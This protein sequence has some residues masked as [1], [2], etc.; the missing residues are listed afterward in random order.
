[1]ETTQKMRIISSGERGS[2][3]PEINIIT[4]L[5]IHLREM[6]EVMRSEDRREVVSFGISPEKALW[7]SYKASVVRR[8]GYIDGKIAAIWGVAGAFMGEIGQPWLLT[9][10]EV[11]KISPLKFARLYQKEVKEMLTIFPKLMNIVDASYESAV[12][13]LDIVGFKLGEPEPI[14]KNGALYCK[15]N[16]GV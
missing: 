3:Q 16:L 11:K 15:F 9:S 1:M 4:T 13:L 5:P 12:R 8:T 2:M 14:G 10:P 6:A 7:R